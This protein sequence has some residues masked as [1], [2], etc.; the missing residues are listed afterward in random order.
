MITPFTPDNKVDFKAIKSLVDWYIEHGSNGI[1]AVCQSSEMFFLKPQEKLDI[2]KAVVDA[3]A[4][5]IKVIASGHT[6]DDKDEQIQ[7]LGNMSQTGVDAV[8]IV[9]NR[10]AKE[11]EGEDIFLKNA[12]AIFKSLPDVKMGLYECPYPYKRLISNE[13][14]AATAKTNKLVFIKDVCCTVEKAQERAEIIK[15]SRLSL[16]NACTATL[17]A[18]LR[19]GY[20]GYNGIMANYHMDLYKWLYDHFKENPETAE[21]LQ[22]FLSVSSMVEARAYPV[23]A[24]WYQNAYGIPMDICTRSKS[25][26]L[27]TESGIE[28][29]KS[30]NRMTN[31]WRKRLGIEL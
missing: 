12:D 30:I 3:T 15:G 31:I 22:D 19:F 25:Q 7:E 14:L 2:A 6:S 10:L 20:Q 11:N 1:F 4:G 29:L 16:F 17:L 26:A 27:L 21:E 23:S 8:V 13:F 18:S 5:R 24:K 9:S 28:E